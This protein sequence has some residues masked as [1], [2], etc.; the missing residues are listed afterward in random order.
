M[1]Y[2]LTRSF[3][4]VF[5]TW[6]CHSKGSRSNAVVESFFLLRTPQNVLWVFFCM[7]CYRGSRFWMYIPSI[8]PSCWRVYGMHCTA[9]QNCQTVNCT[10]TR[11]W[12]SLLL[13]N[14][15]NYEVS[16]PSVCIL[17]SQREFFLQ[18]DR[19][20]L[21]NG[22]CFE[23]I[24]SI[25]WQIV[26]FTPFVNMTYV[27]TLFLWFG[28]RKFLSFPFHIDAITKILSSLTLDFWQYINKL[29]ML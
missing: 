25:F 7:Q 13:L 2:C 19:I 18:Q 24:L 10:N 15:C 1:S 4:P 29:E 12:I 22:S 28:D 8:F 20:R 23:S 3:R 14:G 11:M 27:M 6:D 16:V 17:G 5:A 9:L 21:L 26:R